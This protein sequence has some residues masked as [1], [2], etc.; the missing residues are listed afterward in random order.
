MA[1]KDP[2]KQ[3]EKEQDDLRKRLIWISKEGV[4]IAKEAKSLAK[5]KKA[6]ADVSLDVEA[7]EIRTQ[8]FKDVVSATSA[9]SKILLGGNGGLWD[10]PAEQKKQPE[11][12]K[13]SV[14]DKILQLQN[15]TALGELDRANKGIGRA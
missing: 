10:L 4:A 15:M 14:T 12:N 13:P 11:S 6:G 2:R 9:A 8:A 1:N 3:R 5:Q 7:L